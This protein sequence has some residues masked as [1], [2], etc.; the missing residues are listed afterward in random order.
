MHC[1]LGQGWLGY[2]L[3]KACWK[4]RLL[5]ESRRWW[6]GKTWLNDFPQT[7]VAL[8]HVKASPTE[9]SPFRNDF[10][11]P[12]CL[13]SKWRQ[14]P[15]ALESKY[16]VTTLPSEIQPLLGRRVKEKQFSQ[17]GSGWATGGKRKKTAPRLSD[18]QGR[19]GFLPPEIPSGLLLGDA[20]SSRGLV[21][22]PSPG[23]FF[24]T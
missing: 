18:G 19:A 5:L 2:R 15:N 13:P 21:P 11:F 14:F 16:P 6:P 17:R 20:A 10:S 3:D 8:R 4:A 24:I 23:V 12:K 1:R 7:L 9:P 22:E